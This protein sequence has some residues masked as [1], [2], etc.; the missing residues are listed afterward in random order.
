MSES[1]DVRYTLTPEDYSVLQREFTSSSPSRRI[2]YWVPVFAYP[3]MGI[4]MTHLWW[5]E[6]G[7]IP[8]L[9]A[10][11]MFVGTFFLVDRRWWDRRKFR[12]LR[13]GEAETL[14]TYDADGLTI[15][16]STLGVVRQKWVSLQ[17]ISDGRDHVLLWQNEHAAHIVPKRAFATP[18]H[19]QAFANFALEQ[20]A[21]TK[22]KKSGE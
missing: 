4:L 11:G 15:K 10:I 16:N 9:A 22:F 20:S 1:A 8:A 5:S 21:G 6:G 18:T 12:Q 14:L 3:A 7:A 13:L 17:R 19:A 2:A